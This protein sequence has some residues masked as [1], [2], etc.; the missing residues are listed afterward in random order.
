[1]GS[2]LS[3]SRTPDV[4]REIGERLRTLRLQQNLRTTDLADASGVSERTVRRAEAGEPVSTENLVRILRGL[5][6]L[7]AL[8]A[9]LPPPPLS[10]RQ[11]DRMGG[12][13]RERASG[14][15]RSAPARSSGEPPT[16]RD[17]DRG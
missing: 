16:R 11:I 4:L 5:G 17:D 6:R 12:K 1:M 3:T 14:P 10:P 8:D 15:R 7:Q 9:F 13:V 2:I